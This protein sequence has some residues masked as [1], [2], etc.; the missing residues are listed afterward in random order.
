MKRSSILF[1]VAFFVLGRSATAEEVKATLD[2]LPMNANLETID[3]WPTG[4]IVLFIHG[5]LAHRGMET[6]FGLQSMLAEPGWSALGIN[7]SLGI[8]DRPAETYDC[9]MTHTHKHA[10]AVN[11]IATWVGW[12]KDGGVQRIALLGHSRG[13][14]QAARYAAGPVAGAGPGQ[15]R[16]GC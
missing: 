9:R 4:P 13:G 11:E 12:L 3:T 1:L 16:Q 10:D 5:T 6:I 8:N 2:E 14:N 7:L 15:F